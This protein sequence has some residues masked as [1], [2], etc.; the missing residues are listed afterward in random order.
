M[1]TK[2]LKELDFGKIKNELGS[3]ALATINKLEREW[4]NQY[5][6][7]LG[8]REFFA[9]TCRLAFNSFRAA[10]YIASD[11]R[12]D[13]YTWKQSYVLVVPQITRSILDGIFNV[14]FMLEDLPSRCEFYH[15]SGWKETKLE[16]E[17]HLK[18]YGGKLEW[19]K[20]F[21][22][23]QETLDSGLKI[24]GISATKAADPK[25]IKWWPTPGKMIMYGLS[26]MASPLPPTRVFMEY[27]NDW[28][29][30]NLSAQAHQS[31]HGTLKTGVFVLAERLDLEKQEILENKLMPIFR[32]QQLGIAVD[33]LLA[34]LS[35]IE[36]FFRFGLAPRAQYLWVFLSEYMPESKELYDLRYAEL[37]AKP[38]AP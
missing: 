10:I 37:L 6:K 9:I 29:Y 28:F 11:E 17:K 26:R 23:M 31:L 8:A 21:E 7:V 20:W 15:E 3:L 25:L 5:S 30:R 2:E 24:F 36:V 35:E 14:I 12:N 13:D 18:L 27:L 22:G 34:L 4:P 19:Q 32:S 1:S 38:A 33:L 16:M